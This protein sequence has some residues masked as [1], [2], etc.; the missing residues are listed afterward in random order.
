[1]KFFQKDPVASLQG[2]RDTLAREEAA[3]VALTETRA[4]RLV[5]TDDPTPVAAIDEQ[6]EKHRRNAN[7]LRDK[8]PQ[9]QGEIRRQAIERQEQER[10]AV[11]K[12]IAAKL[13]ERDAKAVELEAAIARVAEL[14]AEIS[15]MRPGKLWPFAPPYQAWGNY[16]W[17]VWA[18][19]E[20]VLAHLQRATH[21]RGHGEFYPLPSTYAAR[22]IA[23][24]A[25]KETKD[26]LE[27]LAKVELPPP[28]LAHEAEEDDDGEAQEEAA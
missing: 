26:L 20:S 24:G 7:V 6:I 14:F 4:Q 10:Q 12:I 9:I 23:E 21:A 5:E 27:E 8:I 2:T 18:L 25:A 15:D 1:M 3:V 19:P 28:A 22:P 17:T 16:R 13:K 11:V